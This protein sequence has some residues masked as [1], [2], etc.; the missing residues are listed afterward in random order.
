MRGT[1]VLLLLS[2]HR[3]TALSVSSTTL[4]LKCMHVTIE[5]LLLTLLKQ[6]PRLQTSYGLFKYQ[7]TKSSI[8]GHFAVITS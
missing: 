6:N 5:I 1:R 4:T 8:Y 3:F 7:R 2:V